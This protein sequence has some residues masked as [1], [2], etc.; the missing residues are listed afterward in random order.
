MN[1]VGGSSSGGL[2]F[3]PTRTIDDTAAVT[4]PLGHPPPPSVAVQRCV[5]LRRQKQE[6]PNDNLLIVSM[7][8]EYRSEMCVQKIVVYGRNKSL[9]VK[10]REILIDVK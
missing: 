8:L 6:S 5:E 1:G 2:S 4:D 3:T 9:K 7:I 10:N